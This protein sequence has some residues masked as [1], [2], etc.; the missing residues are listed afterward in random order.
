MGIII[1]DIC[2]SNSINVLDVEAI[3]EAEYPEVS[4]LMNDCLSFCGMCAR[5]PF[6][7]VNGKRVFAKTPEECLDKIRGQIEKELAIYD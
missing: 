1:V 6:A 4:V 3:L 2:M 7:I 5:S